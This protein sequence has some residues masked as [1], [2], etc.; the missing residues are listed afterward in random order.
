MTTKPCFDTRTSSF[1][2]LHY[3]NNS[4]NDNILSYISTLENFLVALLLK[5]DSISHQ[6]FQGGEMCVRRERMH[7]LTLWLTQAWGVTA[8]RGQPEPPWPEGTGVSCHPR[9]RAMPSQRPGDHLSPRAPKRSSARVVPLLCFSWIF[10]IRKREMENI[11]GVSQKSSNGTR[12]S[13]PFPHLR[14][15]YFSPQSNT[16]S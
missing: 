4:K 7:C 12:T 2:C 6:S 16:A 14:Y 11:L 5:L 15:F 3:A 13:T 8:L 1:C 9:C 10:A